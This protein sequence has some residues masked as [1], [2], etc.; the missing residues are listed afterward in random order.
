MKNASV[1]ALVAFYTLGHSTQADK[2]V[3]TL[4]KQPKDKRGTSLSEGN[5]N[6]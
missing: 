4:V 6:L 1:P 5:A 2:R 3:G